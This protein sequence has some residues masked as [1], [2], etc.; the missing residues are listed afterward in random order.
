MSGQ[1]IPRIWTD[2]VVLRTLDRLVKGKVNKRPGRAYIKRIL[3]KTDTLPMILLQHQGNKSQ[4]L[5]NKVRN[6]I[7]VPIVFNTINLK[8]LPTIF[9][10]L[11]LPA[12]EALQIWR[13]RINTSN[14][15]RRRKL[16]PKL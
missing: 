15:F 8:F 9:E 6:I 3:I 12:L 2:K 5:A 4:I 11:R 13:A 1:L 16:I 7:K 14:G 10:F